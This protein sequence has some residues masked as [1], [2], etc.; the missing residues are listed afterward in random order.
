MYSKSWN[1][2]S[3]NYLCLSPAQVNA[4]NGYR[5]RLQSYKTYLNMS[6]NLLKTKFP[7]NISRKLIKKGI[8]R[9]VIC[10]LFVDILVVR[11]RTVNPKD[12]GSISD[13]GSGITEILFVVFPLIQPC[14]PC[15][16]LVKGIRKLYINTNWQN[17]N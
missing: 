11:C 15:E 2:D 9:K 13:L 3:L 5:I 14:G 16:Y 6:I 12:L 10:I 8:T 1:W 17:P 7:N 4:H